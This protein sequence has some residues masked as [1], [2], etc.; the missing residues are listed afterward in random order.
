MLRSTLG[1]HDSAQNYQAAKGYL[2]QGDGRIKTNAKRNVDETG[3]H[4]VIMDLHKLVL[5][6]GNCK[7]AV[8]FKI[9]YI[10]IVKY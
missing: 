6:D 1:T 5:V 4:T 3:T 9:K 8:A 10:K 2:L 7:N